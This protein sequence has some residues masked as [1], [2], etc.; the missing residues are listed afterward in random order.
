MSIVRLENLNHGGRVAGARQELADLGILLRN[1]PQPEEMRFT[2]GM[3]CCDTVA[4]VKGHIIEIVWKE[5]NF[6]ISPEMLTMPK[7]EDCLLLPP[8][9]REHDLVKSLLEEAWRDPTKMPLVDPQIPRILNGLVGLGVRIVMPTATSATRE[10]LDRFLDYRDLPI[11]GVI[12]RTSTKEKLNDPRT[13]I[14]EGFM[15]DHASVAWEA[16]ATG[17]P[18][19]LLSRPWNRGFAGL[20]KEYPLVYLAENWTEADPLLK[21]MCR[22]D[23][24]RA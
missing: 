19:I 14:I 15:D 18:T 10:Q 7:L 17:R 1:V 22:V 3:D 9:L 21:K 2:L 23:D 12:H 16:A 4:D 8:F 24:I 20:V 13:A 11:H 5:H 6:R